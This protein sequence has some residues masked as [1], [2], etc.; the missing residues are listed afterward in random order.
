MAF[1]VVLSHYCVFSLVHYQSLM[2]RLIFISILLTGLLQYRLWFGENNLSEFFSLREQITSQQQSN[3]KLVARNQVLKE[4]I[5]ELANGTE[6]LEERARNELGM[7]KEGETFYRVVNTTN[8]LP[9][10]Q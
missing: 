3:A 9:S 1:F 2:K 6:A 8:K 5:F 4:E 7:V 10:S